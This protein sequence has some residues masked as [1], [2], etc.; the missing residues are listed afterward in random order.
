M[1]C[2]AMSPITAGAIGR[3]AIWIVGVALLLA[4]AAKL[5][6][7]PAFADSLLAW[8]LLPAWSRGIVSVAV[9]TSEVLIAGLWVV[10]RLRSPAISW[11]M[12]GMLLAFTAAYLA[13]VQM[14]VAPQCACFGRIQLFEES[15][16]GAREVIAR[17][18]L[19]C[20]LLL[21]GIST[22]LL[23]ARRGGRPSLAPTLEASGAEGAHSTRGFTL[24]ES[25]I[26][27]LMLAILLALVLPSLRTAR[28]QSRRTVSLSNLRSHVQVFSVYA[29]DFTDTWPYFTDPRATQTVLYDDP[30][31]GVFPIEYFLAHAF[32]NVALAPG[33]YEGNARHPSFSD[34]GRPPVVSGTEYYWYSCA[35]IAA[36]SYWNP[37]T[38]VGPSQWVPTFTY[39]VSFA[40]QKGVLLAP[41]SRPDPE[42]PDGRVIWGDP[43]GVGFCD[44]S[45][46]LVPHHALQKV[47]SGG[48]GSWPGGFH[49]SGVEV[50]HTIDGVAGRDVQ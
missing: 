1:H 41:F 35:F 8:S 21:V 30:N 19:L 13:H 32:W 11:L 45:A 39:Q 25:I 16:T 12:L 31:G 5:W 38:R 2:G 33:Y 10:A 20:G 9:P 28:E 47:Y 29:T 44:G 7:L 40:A 37:A 43:R 49:R 36:H 15:R 50:L 18:L 6:D 48:D 26:V 23:A 3:A 42:Q 14:G 17:N 4:G 34:P 24:I 22:H 46:R 27:V